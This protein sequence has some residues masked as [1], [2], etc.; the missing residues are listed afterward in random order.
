M[1][2]RPSPLLTGTGTNSRR[3]SDGTTI[4][5][6]SSDNTVSTYVLP[7]DLLESR[8]ESLTLQRQ[9]T[10][11]LPEPT[12]VIAP[13]PYFSLSYPQ[14]QTFLAGCRE[15]P[16]QLFHAL[17]DT[18]DPRP[19][20]PLSSF[21]LIKPQ[22]EEYLTPTAMIWPSPGT[23]FITGTANLLAQFDITRTGEGPVRR[24]PTIPSTRHLSKG[25]GVG[26]R[27]TVSALSAQPP[28]ASGGSLVAAGT[29]TRWV[30][31]YDFARG[32]DC[33]ATWSIAAAA[34]AAEPGEGAGPNAKGIG[35]LG[36]LQTIWSPCGRYLLINERQS[37]GMLVYDVRVTGKMLGW[38][39]G[40]DALTHQ[41]L[42]CDVYPGT[43]DTGGFEVWAGTQNGTVN[44][45]EGVGNT[46]GSMEASW[47]M[48]AHG[49]PIGGT[50]MH[51]SGSVLA[52][53]SGSWTVPDAV[54]G[55]SD[56]ETSDE[57]SEGSLEGHIPKAHDATLK[58]WS[59][60][61]STVPLPS[62]A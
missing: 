55:D 59:I 29:W 36:I 30:G 57:E 41:R 40:R 28:D 1:V 9:S 56:D 60:K 35:G 39:A 16:I 7:Q 23:H 6:S 32:G 27:G 24:V 31:L 25:G 37:T 4:I 5:T 10:L 38:L 61:A 8:D 15:H 54:S 34:A 2:R 48:E 46:E 26:M 51:A 33:V 13:S 62:M 52:T 47:D 17:P 45:W 43:S 21:N 49:S 50:A 20:Q 18:D 12:H 58:I 11:A 53:C 42:T 22:T 19:N 3:T 14:T 44:M